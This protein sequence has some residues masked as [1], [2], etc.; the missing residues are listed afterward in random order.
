MKNKFIRTLL[1]ALIVGVFVIWGTSYI[2]L[3]TMGPKTKAAGDTIALS[4]L[5]TSFV[6]I[7]SNYEINVRIL[8]TPS[9]DASFRGYG[10]NLNFDKTKLSFKSITYL[11]GS[12]SNGLG[13]TTNDV[14]A[15]NSAGVVKV[16]GESQSSTGTL[17][18]SSLGAEMI[19]VTFKIL[20]TSQNN[21]TISSPSFYSLNSD[22]SLYSGWTYT[23][24]VLSVNGTAATL[25]NTPTPTQTP[26]PIPTSTTMPGEPTSTPAI[27]STPVPTATT[28]P[29]ETSTPEPNTNVT[30]N[31][32]LR[33]QGITKKPINSLNSMTVKVKLKK[34]SDTTIIESSGI[35][36]ADDDGIW[37]GSAGF[38]MNPVPTENIFVVYIKG[39]L[40]IQ[41]KIC[42]NSPT[43]TSAGTY[44]CATN[45]IA[46]KPGDNNLDFSNLTMLVGDLDQNGIVDS[47]DYAMIRN[48]LSKTDEA[49]LNKSD[50][51]RD[52]RVDTQDFSLII[53]ALGVRVD[54]Q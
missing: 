50:L 53:A 22:S 10:M 11:V 7:A 17:V 34:P 12:V 36:T 2:F 3:S 18:T 48:N 45:N 44:S 4:F 21:I 25:T 31:L 40:H 13:N 5:P 23:Q 9:K 20:N 54:E 37:S 35:F 39:A 19:T 8:A 41:K 49:T 47:V 26:T 27:T 42:D 38:D 16:V 6:N 52:G 15:I 29:E 43:E 33:F 32:K 24:T 51:N 30:L 1:L 28:A 14:T 46:L